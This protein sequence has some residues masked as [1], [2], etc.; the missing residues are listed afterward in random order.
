MKKLYYL[1]LF[2]CAVARAQTTERVTGELDTPVYQDISGSPFFIN[3]W[4]DGVIRFS[5]GR[6]TNQFKI[7][8]DVIQNR[9]LLQFNGSSFATESKIREFVI[10]PGGLKGKDSMIFRKGFPVNGPA[11]EETFY[12]VMLSGKSSLLCL[13]V[14]KISEERQIASKTV[15]RRIFDEFEYYLLKEGKL[16]KLSLMKQEVSALFPD[17]QEALKKYIDENQLRFKDAQDLVTL[18]KFYNGL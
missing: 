5:S 13:P 2:C 3:A 9:V 18:V 8:F 10:Y 4:N 6:T 14:K 11:N 15:Y 16:Y 17:Q 7:R 1:L 12:R